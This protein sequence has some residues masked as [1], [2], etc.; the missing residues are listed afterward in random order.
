MAQVVLPEE[1]QVI[2]AL[3][4]HAPQE[5]LGNRVGAWRADGRA[6]DGD[7]ARRG[8]LREARAILAVVVANEELGPS[9]IRRRLAQLLRRP[10]VRRVA[11]DAL[12]TP[13]RVEKAAH[14]PHSTDRPQ[15][16]G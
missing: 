1:Q 2:E 15:N 5:A 7:I 12:S 13:Q 14:G 16:R 3:P 9:P 4:P 11:R 8:H 6:R 10:L